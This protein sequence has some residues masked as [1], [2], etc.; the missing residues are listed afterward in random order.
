MITFLDEND[1]E[2][3]AQTTIKS[4]NAVN[5]ERS[6]SGEIVTG[7][8]VISHIER[9][10]RLRF[11]DEYYVVTYAKPIDEGRT[12]SVTFDAVH[13]F[14]WDFDKSSLHRQLSDGSHTFQAYLDFIFEGSGY[15][16]VIDS[17][18]KIPAFEKQ[19]FGYKS[20][21]S[22]FNDIV[23]STGVEFQ[24]NGKVVRILE[25]V[26]TDLST[27]VRKNFN[28][29]EL[30]IEKN[31]GD[32]VTYQKGFGA[33]KD[34]ED[35][36]KGR[37]EIEYISPLESVYGRLE[38]EPLVDERYTKESS[39]LS[40][41]KNN[42]DNSY[43]ISV[44]LDIEDLT[45]A[46]YKYTQPIA[47][48]YI[49]AIN[50]TL[51]F[52]EKIRIVSFTSEYDVTGQLIK[53][54]VTCND[55][56]FV[57][58]QSASYSVAKKQASS[59]VSSAQ[60]ALEVA[61][62][63]L[64]SANGKN[65]IFR[66]TDFPKDEPKGTLHV[67]DLLFLTVGDVVKQ[68]RWNGADWEYVT[69]EDYAKQIKE[70]VDSQ[71][72]EVTQQ[73]A[74]QQQAH[75]RT[76]ADILTKVGALQNLATE[77]ETIGNQ[78]KLDAAGALAQANQAKID[79]I[80]EANRLVELSKTTL[81]NQIKSVDVKVD[82]VANLITSKVSQTDFD[83]LKGTVTGQQ[84][85]IEQT[86]AKIA[87]KADKT[88]TDNL[89]QQ[90]SQTQADLSVA[91]DKIKALVTKTDFD[92]LTGRM[93]TAE[94]QL[95]TQAGL[96]EQRLTST[97]VEAAINAKGYQTEAQVD[98][99]IAGRGYITSSA[100]QP[101][102]LSTTVQNLVKE[103]ADS[104]SRTISETKAL[105]PTEIGSRN[106]IRGS[107]EMKK[108]SGNW[109][110]GTF[111]HSGP[112]S[113]VSIDISDFPAG[114]VSKAI[115]IS[116]Q[117]A[118]I[119]QDNFAIS[120]GDWTLSYWV[121]ATKGTVVR[122]Q[123]YYSGSNTSTGVSRT[124]S[125]AMDGWQRISFTAI[126]SIAETL[127]IAY[128]YIHAGTE[129]IVTA[130]QLE[131]GKLLTDHSPAPEDFA[132]VTAL[133][134]VNDTVNSHTR[135]ITE[136]GKSIS[137]VI[138]TANSLIN[139]VDNLSAGV[140]NYLA[141]TAKHPY[142]VVDNVTN[143]KVFDWYNLVSGKTMAELGF[144]VGDRVTLQYDLKRYSPQSG[145]TSVTNYRL[146]F[147][148][149]TGYVARFGD[150]YVPEAGSKKITIELTSAMLAATQ[151]KLRVDNSNTI[152]EFNET[153]LVKGS[154]S[155]DWSPAPEDSD[156]ALS[157]VST[158]VSQLAGSWAVKNLTSGGAVLNQIN[159]LANGTNLID[160]RLTHITGDTLIDRGVIKSAMIGNGQIGT[161]QIGTIDAS[162][163]NII[164]I[165][166]SN[167]TTNGLSA[168]VIKGGTLGALNNVTNFN[169]QTGWI[170]MN[171]ES[172]GIKNQFSDQPI[173]YL[174]FGRGAI[175]GK[176]GTY[177]ALMSNSNKKVA[178]D[179]GSAGIQIWNTNDN[180]TAVNLY[181]DELALMYN[182]TD[183]DG[184]VINNISNTI[185]GVKNINLSSYRNIG[186]KEI[187]NDI[188][189]NLAT[190]HRVKTTETA[191]TY[192]MY[193][194]V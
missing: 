174:V 185:S 4:T 80:T 111:R 62:R 95:V 105:I 32:F 50:E 56:G 136:Q 189:N 20:R 118:G 121:K 71:F 97:Q 61:N 53:H 158:T 186:L 102:A 28:L 87:L 122:L 144:V 135:T 9:G 1:I 3:G 128:I 108:G 77:A 66:G 120:E 54:T 68:Y 75:D 64:V 149:A 145:T 36:S 168:N 21:L 58:K 2:H 82:N 113:S 192:S 178:M 8:Y 138:Q 171:N 143:Y 167:I 179:D 18:L 123:A 55:I 150:I 38:A 13:Q 31:I 44:T 106:Y 67:G 146:E 163:A 131:K 86:T 26:G 164:N 19:S 115:K 194:P 182:A 162:Q 48:D 133:H 191:Y 46:G 176:A 132:T 134:T 6:L 107:L 151:I 41:L 70:Q 22:L 39:L 170:E 40:V 47:G 16:Y 15:S 155:V 125:L 165:N 84:T 190:L 183:K 14:F 156:E 169:L 94:T 34:S 43:T 92:R 103:T 63:A 117:G 51:S 110:D 188:Y 35:H 157:A 109:N 147:Y 7:D 101:Y 139:R 130:P 69:G 141:N 11:N 127:S 154:M 129:I 74:E 45:R 172:V 126:N 42:V 175:N 159:L 49:M 65:S 24:V 83:K 99:N 59:A 142:I 30:G 73:I 72:A 124:I 161:A 23:T 27:V 100:L 12:V 98:S 152:L 10:W 88:A 60:N 160:G 93:T 140:R 89:S 114:Y 180:T 57:K 181:G 90:I 78:A 148:N 166:A 116:G 79:A 76:V 177:T 33:W 25:R 184:I 5:G 91:N 17:L 173:Q 104:F 29:N 81:T 85:T 37:L 52:Q 112:G 153:R 96:I 137:Q 119:A 193:G 187:L